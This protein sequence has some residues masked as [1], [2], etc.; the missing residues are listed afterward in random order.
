MANGSESVNWRRKAKVE[1]TNRGPTSGIFIP[2][3]A[4]VL[5]R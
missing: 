4:P 3:V 5:K 2:P 1:G